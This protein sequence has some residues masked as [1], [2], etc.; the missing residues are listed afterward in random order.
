VIFGP[1]LWENRRH[2]DCDMAGEPYMSKLLF[3][4][5]DA[6]LCAVGSRVL[7]RQGHVVTTAAH[8]GHAALACM[9]HASFD[10]LVIEQEMPEAPGAAIAQRLRR[11]SPDWQIVWMCDA[12]AAIPQEGIAVVRP[13][14]ADDLTSAA[15][16]AAAASA[17]SLAS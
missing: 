3:V 9:E 2:P 1:F 17:T 8:G 6:D 4:S 11:Y 14:T 16:A 5:D 10:V 12:G 15:L 7:A 13:F